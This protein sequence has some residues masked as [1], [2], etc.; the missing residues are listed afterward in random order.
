MLPK[1]LREKDLINRP[2]KAD[3]P[4]CVGLLNI[5]KTT[6]WTW[7]NI[8]KFPKP[9]KLSARVTVWKAEDVE[10]FLAEVI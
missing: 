6:L 4:A 3:Q 9:I 10:K 7:V 8:G 1:L 5:S 2:A